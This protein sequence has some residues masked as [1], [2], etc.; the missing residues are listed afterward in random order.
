MFTYTI[1][2]RRFGAMLA[3]VT[4]MTVWAIVLTVMV[5]STAVAKELQYE[6]VGEIEHGGRLTFSPSGTNFTV[7]PGSW[8]DQF[9]AVYVLDGEVETRRLPWSR[10]SWRAGDILSVRIPETGDRVLLP[11]LQYARDLQDA[12]PGTLSGL[13]QLAAAAWQYTE[14]SAY[15][16]RQAD[17]EP[18]F[19]SVEELSGRT[20]EAF[21]IRDRESESFPFAL[22]ASSRCM[23]QAGEIYLMNQAGDRLSAARGI[24]SHHPSVEELYLV[25]DE[26]K[27]LVNDPPKG[28][29]T[30]YRLEGTTGRVLAI[31]DDFTL[32][33]DPRT[34]QRRYFAQGRSE[35]GVTT[36]I[37]HHLIPGREELVVVN[38]QIDPDNLH[39]YSHEWVE[40]WD[41]EGEVLQE[42]PTGP[43]ENVEIGS[44]IHRSNALLIVTVR[45]KELPSEDPSRSVLQV[46]RASSN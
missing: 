21:D 20:H 38:R 12:P 39:A 18:L 4:L 37:K 35:D 36:L 27:T 1:Q 11:P 42:L 3:V 40:I 23:T 30:R 8:E 32:V 5:Q 43:P 17:G 2:P 33:Y 26:E 25:Q 28:R 45:R 10:G 34:E 19:D 46:Y 16:V 44:R 14:D 24:G 31:E 29:I 13:D 6:K 15:S 9:L 41:A 22:E 7:E